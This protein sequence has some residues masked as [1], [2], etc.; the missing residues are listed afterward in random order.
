MY[1]VE[2]YWNGT[3]ILWKVYGGGGETTSLFGE[4]DSQLL[5]GWQVYLQT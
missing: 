4:V 3:I 2:L 1:F 5:S